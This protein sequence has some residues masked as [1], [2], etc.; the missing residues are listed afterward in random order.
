VITTAS[1][2]QGRIALDIWA[3]ERGL[4]VEDNE[5][6]KR[7]SAKI[8]NGKSVKVYAGNSIVLPEAPDEFNI[9]GSPDKAEVIIS[10]E[11]YKRKALYLRPRKPFCRHRL[12]PGTTRDEVQNEFTWLQKKTGCPPI[13]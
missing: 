13:P 11:L 12:Q 8:V 1:D 10:E 5:R 6:L 9:V 4:Y 3:D 7:L 2:V